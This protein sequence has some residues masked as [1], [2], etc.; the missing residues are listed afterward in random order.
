MNLFTIIQ[1][2]LCSLS[3]IINRAVKLKKINKNKKYLLR[4]RKVSFLIFIILP[5]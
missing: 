1:D 2:F 4:I 3:C 5:V